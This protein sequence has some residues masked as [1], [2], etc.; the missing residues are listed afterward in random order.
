MRRGSNT[1]REKLP[2]QIVNHTFLE[3]GE[4]SEQPETIFIRSPQL[5]SRSQIWPPR[6]WTKSIAVVSSKYIS[7]CQAKQ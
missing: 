2:I 6:H 7:R 4:H 3:P 5:S 1:L